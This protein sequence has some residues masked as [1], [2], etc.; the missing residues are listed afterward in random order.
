MSGILHMPQGGAQ[1]SMISQIPETVMSGDPTVQEMLD[2]LGQYTYVIKD[3]NSYDLIANLWENYEIWE[4]APGN[5][6][7]VL[8][9]ADKHSGLNFQPQST[10]HPIT[11]KAMFIQRTINLSSN[12]VIGFC[13]LSEG[14]WGSTEV[15]IHLIPYDANKST[16]DYINQ[17]KNYLDNNIANGIVTMKF[18]HN[19][20]AGQNDLEGIMLG[21][22]TSAGKFVIGITVNSNQTNVCPSIYNLVFRTY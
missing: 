13:K 2:T 21:E 20:I 22:L 12:R 10:M 3:D 11:V 14:S 6:D 8:I 15:R 17:L 4:R 18:T 1:V 7:M 16:A 5:G 19:G 9:N